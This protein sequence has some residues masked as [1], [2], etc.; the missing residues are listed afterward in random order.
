M[1]L[2]LIVAE[3]CEGATARSL[4][5]SAIQN[6]FRDS[7]LSGWGT[8]IGPGPRVVRGRFDGCNL[9]IAT[10]AAWLIDMPFTEEGIRSAQRE[11]QLRLLRALDML[12]GEPQEAEGETPWWWLAP[13]LVPGL[14]I[15]AAPMLLGAYALSSFAR[16]QGHWDAAFV[17]Y[18]QAA[19]GD[20]SWWRSGSAINTRTRDTPDF[21]PKE[22][23]LGPDMLLPVQV[24]IVDR[25]R[26]V[27]SEVI[28]NVTKVA[29]SIATLIAV[30]YLV[31][32]L[33]RW[34][35]SRSAFAG[36][37]PL[38]PGRIPP[39]RPPVAPPP[40]RLPPPVVRR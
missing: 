20:E 11:I 26:Q 37:G 30:L 19:S 35:A 39:G 17:P 33:A 22:N 12:D 13:A 6:A 25:G 34:I 7:V 29:L 27:Q 32:V 38:P 36:P 15:G 16:S 23:V 2:Y 28:G 14:A 10:K 4:T 9:A 3:I 40:R 31:P 8:L 18:S 21:G 24:T 5:Y 1:A